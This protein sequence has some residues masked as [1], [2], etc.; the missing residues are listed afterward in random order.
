[1]GKGEH[2]NI[3]VT[4]KKEYKNVWITDSY[5]KKEKEMVGM[6]LRDNEVSPKV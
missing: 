6:V 1:M 3:L 5:E 2:K 4:E